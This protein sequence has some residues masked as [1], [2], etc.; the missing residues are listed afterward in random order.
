M[1]RIRLAAILLSAS[2]WATDEFFEY[3]ST[4]GGY[5]ELHFNQKKLDGVDWGDAVLDFHR[6]VL[7]YGYAWTPEWSFKSE[8]E[9]EHNFVASGTA[10]EDD[11]GRV[12]GISGFG[13]LELEQAFINYAFNSAVNFQVGV[14][15]PSVGILNETHEPPTFFGVERPGYNSKIIPT[16]W[17]GNGLALAGIAGVL[18]YKLVIME[19]LNSANFSPSGGLRSGRQNGFKA[20]LNNILLNMR[21]DYT[22]VHGLRAG[23]SYSRNHLISNKLDDQI[24]YSVNL[25]EGHMKYLGYNMILVSEAGNIVYD[26]INSTAIAVTG[27]FGYYLQAGYNVFSFLK[28]DAALYPFFYWT[29]YN[30]GEEIQNNSIAQEDNQISFWSFGLHFLP[31]PEVVFKGDFGIEVKGPNDDKKT[32]LNLGVGYYF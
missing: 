2:V 31:I 1:K 29:Q 19:G 15:L 11:S 17:F 3:K 6:F 24:Y 14:V 18:D 28:T 8:V 10:K 27:S 32:L 4:L 30:P 12:I 9:L 5:G 7:F 26:P 13:E 25:I 16:T 20:K 22:G 23:A 21:A